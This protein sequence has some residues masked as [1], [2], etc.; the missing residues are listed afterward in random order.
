LPGCLSCQS[1]GSMASRCK[2]NN[3]GVCADGNSAPRVT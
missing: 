3:T 2:G 1:V